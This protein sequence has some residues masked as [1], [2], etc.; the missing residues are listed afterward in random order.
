MNLLSIQQFF[1]TKLENKSNKEEQKHKIARTQKPV[2]VG[3]TLDLFSKWYTFP[4]LHLQ[5]HDIN[6]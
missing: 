3:D 6:H 4:S 5:Y 2:S 1:E